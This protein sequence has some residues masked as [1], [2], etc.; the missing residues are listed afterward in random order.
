VGE[1]GHGLRLGEQPILVERA[2][3]AVRA[4]ELDRD[5][6]VEVLVVGG[7]DEAHAALADARPRPPDPRPSRRRGLAA[8]TDLRGPTLEPG[9]GALGQVRRLAAGEQAGLDELAGPGPA[10]GARSRG[11]SARN[12]GDLR[13]RQA[14][15]VVE[16]EE[17]LMLERDLAERGEEVAELLALPPGPGWARAGGRRARPTRS[18]G[19]RDRGA[20]SRKWR[21]SWL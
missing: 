14:L 20:L 10:G 21:Q 7:E 2:R 5:L 16:L 3:G 18:R 8:C 13:G 12:L 17:D 19:G 1:P 4:Q 15:P 11:G 6:A 9:E